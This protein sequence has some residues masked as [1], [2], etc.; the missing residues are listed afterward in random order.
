M[1]T[2]GSDVLDISGWGVF[3]SGWGMWEVTMFGW[4]VLELLIPGWK[5][6]ISIPA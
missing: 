5:V 6:W 3:I 2:P 1:M 4:V